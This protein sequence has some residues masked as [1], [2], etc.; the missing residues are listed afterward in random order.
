MLKNPDAF[1]STACQ[2]LFEP[3][4]KKARRSKIRKLSG[5]RKC[6]TSTTKSGETILNMIHCTVIY[7]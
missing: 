3:F 1:E 4:Y 6:D 7:H 5:E 2:N